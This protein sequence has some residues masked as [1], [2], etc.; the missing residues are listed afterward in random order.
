MLAALL[1][2]LLAGGAGGGIR[3]ASAVFVAAAAIDV[4][5]GFAGGAIG[6][7]GADLRHHS[8]TVRAR[9]SSRS[10]II[11]CVTFSPRAALG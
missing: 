8:G 10:R 6:S 3:A 9:R 1:A 2:A 7:A 11:S 4:D 5:G